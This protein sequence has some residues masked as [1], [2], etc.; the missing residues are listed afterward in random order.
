MAAGECMRDRG[1]ENGGCGGE[2]GWGLE[3]VV[4]GVE[5]GSVREMKTRET[6]L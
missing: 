3:G 2:G 4:W 5:V 1:W 6:C